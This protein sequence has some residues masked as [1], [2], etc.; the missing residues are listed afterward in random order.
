MDVRGQWP[1]GRVLAGRT[2][3]DPQSGEQEGA[4]AGPAGR[5]SA[6]DET[7]VLVAVS[8]RSNPV[9]HRP[10]ASPDAEPDG[11]EETA[12]S[13]AGRHAVAWVS[14]PREVLGAAWSW[15]AD[16]V[17]E[18]PEMA[19]RTSAAAES[20]RSVGCVSPCRVED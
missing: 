14:P 19:L 6:S 18:A 7:A 15:S 10:A 16:A 9:S 13:T 1:Q 11:T 8:V 4:Y 12:A 2:R 17:E 3:T 5:R 20:R